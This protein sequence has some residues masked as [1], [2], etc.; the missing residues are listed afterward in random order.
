MSS[1][2]A[3]MKAYDTTRRARLGSTKSQFGRVGR[4]IDFESDKPRLAQE[5]FVE[6]PKA[7]QSEIDSTDKQL[8]N[9]ISTLENR[10]ESEEN[11]SKNF[12][13]V[14]GP[15][16]I[17]NASATT[18]NELITK[19]QAGG[20]FIKAWT[21]VDHVVIPPVIQPKKSW[22]FPNYIV[23]S[24]I[25]NA[26]DRCI[27]GNQELSWICPSYF[28]LATRLYYATMFYIQILKAKEAAG[29]LT[30]SES[31]WFRSFKR[32]FPLESLPIAGPMVP[33]FSNIVSVKP[34]DDKYDFIYP[35]YRVNQGLRVDK[36]KPTIDVEYYIQPNTTILA[37]FL[38]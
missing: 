18:G 14:E 24:M 8:R 4:N 31:T 9:E 16:T 12:K 13:K 37:E 35:D 1:K 20:A 15:A 23:G 22:Y 34:N 25:V 7:G 30:R 3:K 33:Y 17:R 2:Q 38:A 21:V 19:H 6:R 32:V 28:S 26:M 27:D 29:K 10:A 11:D 5:Q 36:G